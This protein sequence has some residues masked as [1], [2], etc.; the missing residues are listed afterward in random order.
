MVH[1]GHYNAC[2]EKDDDGTVKYEPIKVIEAWGWGYPF[3]MACAVKYIL[4]APF[5]GSE[6]ADLEKTLWYLERAQKNA[7]K[8]LPK[9]D[10]G[11]C[12]GLEVA[13][14]WKLSGHLANAIEAIGMDSPITA[15]HHVTLHLMDLGRY[16][17]D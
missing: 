13:D 3:C 6:R 12:G 7:P 14:A 8:R 11:A 1:P 17:D 15:A 2:G 9:L 16:G 5:K 4:R 10:A